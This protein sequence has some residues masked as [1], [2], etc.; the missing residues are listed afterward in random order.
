M[1]ENAPPN[2]PTFSLQRPTDLKVF[3]EHANETQQA[4]RLEQV[5]VRPTVLE[6]LERLRIPR[7]TAS[8]TAK[9]RYAC[10]EFGGGKSFQTVPNTE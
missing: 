6:H 10:V 5:V 4:P 8:G 3:L 7:C 1:R 9:R 2:E